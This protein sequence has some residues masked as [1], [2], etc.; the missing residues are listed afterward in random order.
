[1]H[2]EYFGAWSVSDNRW[3]GPPEAKGAELPESAGSEAET[4]VWRDGTVQTAQYGWFRHQPSGCGRRQRSAVVRHR[5]AEE[6]FWRYAFLTTHEQ[7][8]SARLAFEHHRLKGEKER[9][10]S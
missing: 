9:W 7:E 5:A 10:L 3:T 8:G 4:A 2:R 6:L 1:V